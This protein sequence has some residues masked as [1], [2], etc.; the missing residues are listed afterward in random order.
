MKKNFLITTGI[1]DTWEFSENNFLLGK[2]CEF[3]EFNNFD[4]NKIEINNKN[5]SIFKNTYHWDDNEKKE[6][7]YKYL[8]DIT[9]Y[10]LEEI[11]KKLSL[12]HEMN[13][14][15]DYWRIIISNWLNEY[16]TAI[17]DS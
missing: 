11:S 14:S 10:L 7:D 12:I 5:I 2:W 3:Y 6:K 1:I 8:T 17:F 16:T 15:K 13:E 4:K 9:E